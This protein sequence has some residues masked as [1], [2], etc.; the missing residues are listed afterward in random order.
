MTRNYSHHS[1]RNNN[2]SNDN[3]STLS[4]SNYLLSPVGNTVYLPLTNDDLIYNGN[5]NRCK[6]PE[7]KL[8]ISKITRDLN[9]LLHFK[10]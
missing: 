2:S 5:L 8:I 7:F 10:D 4:P 3:K 1:S 6:D 9:M